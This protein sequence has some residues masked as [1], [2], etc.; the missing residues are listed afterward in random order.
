VWST[1]LVLLGEGARNERSVM[2][3]ELEWRR[4]PGGCCVPLPCDDKE[5]F[6]TI[7]FVTVSPTG[8]GDEVCVRS[9]AAAA[10]EDRLAL[11][12]RSRRKAFV[13]ARDAFALGGALEACTWR[14]A[15]VHA[16]GKAT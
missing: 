15:I 2:D 14:L 11:D 10:A 16:H 1:G 13:A 5:A 8:V 3:P 6:R 7:R 9:A 4:K 12:S